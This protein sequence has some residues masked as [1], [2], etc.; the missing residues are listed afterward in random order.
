MTK[1]TVCLLLVCVAGHWITLVLAVTF[2]SPVQSKS[3][4]LN[5]CAVLQ[6]LC[7]Y[8]RRPCAQAFQAK[9]PMQPVSRGTTRPHRTPEASRETFDVLAV[10]TLRAPSMDGLLELHPHGDQGDI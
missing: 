5:V 4:S 1:C 9:R 10:Q 8:Q 3:Q 7:V 2:S 6:D